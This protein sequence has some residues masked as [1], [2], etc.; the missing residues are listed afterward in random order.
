MEL[1]SALSE[2]PELESSQVTL[3]LLQEVRQKENAMKN[4]QH[5][6]E[7]TLEA[8][9]KEV[10]KQVHF[11]S[12]QKMCSIHGCT[13]KMCRENTFYSPFINLDE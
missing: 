11:K 13:I 5:K 10:E 1:E 12:C 8:L 3:N 7:E 6:H 4:M 2:H 9:K